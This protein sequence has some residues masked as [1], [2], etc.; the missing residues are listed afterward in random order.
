MRGTP[1][2]VRAALAVALL[3]ALLAAAPAHA[4]T[5]PGQAVISPD[6]AHLYVSDY[7]RTFALDRD[8]E[9]GRLTLAGTYRHG[10]ARFEFSPDGRHLYGV[11]SGPSSVRA[12][13]RDA[14]T[15]SLSYVGRWAQPA[16]Q[17]IGD[18]EFD[19]DGTLYATD[20]IRAQLVV[21]DRD[22]D[23]GRLEARRYLR[24]GVDAPEGLA[25]SVLAR[26][27][28]R[29]FVYAAADDVAPFTIGADGGLSIDF[30]AYTT[31]PPPADARPLVMDHVLYA[32]APDGRL[33]GHGKYVARGTGG[34]GTAIAV[35][36]SV[37][38]IDSQDSRI[39][40]YEGAAPEVTLR[41]S[42]YEGRD[43]RGINYARSLVAS[44]DGRFVYVAFGPQSP[45]MGGVALFARDPATGDLT[46]VETIDG[47]TLEPGNTQAPPARP[48]TLTINEGD[49]YTND[50]DVLV[51][52][53]DT[54]IGSYAF[55]IAN[56]GGFKGARR[57]S[58]DETGTYPWTLA[59]SGP[60]R[61]PKTVHVRLV[62]LDPYRG[63]ILSD[64]IVLDE[65]PPEVTSATTRSGRIAI[66]AR[67]KVSGV[68]HMQVTRNPKKPGRWRRFSKKAGIPKGRGAIRVRVRDRATNTSKWRTVKR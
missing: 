68:A 35:G 27:D 23:S 51:S 66:A 46:F 13:A 19:G 31:D 7:L 59:S 17:G 54:S 29:L 33:H 37:Y 15:G 58:L 47:Y 30:D 48:A 28:R 53:A 2:I 36:D 41:R 43:G 42:Y 3:T 1:L 10:G 57:M 14:A 6:G 55:D 65:R 8:R 63:Q 40:Q 45:G 60:E 61:L 67:D 20:S 22:P 32:L 21:L 25:G 50:R 24:N 18:I 16:S 11:A 26:V 56:D 52:I 5:Q 34:P 64:D 49:E 39:L 12:F 62:E 4:L 44:P 38:A 9:T